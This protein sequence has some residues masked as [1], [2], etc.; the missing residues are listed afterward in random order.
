MSDSVRERIFDAIETQLK[1]ITVLAGYK[2]PFNAKVYRVW[3]SVDQSVLPAIKMVDGGCSPR[4]AQ[5]GQQ[6][7]EMALGV[8]G[9]AIYTL[10]V[11]AAKTSDNILQDIVKCVTSIDR[12]LSGLCENIELVKIGTVLPE[13]GST[14]VGARVEIKITY[15]TVLGDPYTVA[16]V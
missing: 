6:F 13:D 4:V 14:T 2:T 7:Y 8:E 3:Q 10:G 12:T 5:Y 15:A 16:Q 9:V 11:N 1:T